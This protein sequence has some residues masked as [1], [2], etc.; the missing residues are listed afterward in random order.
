MYNMSVYRKINMHL[1]ADILRNDAVIIT[2][3][4]NYVKMT[5]FWRHNDVIITSSVRWAV[6]DL[7]SPA[8][9][10]VSAETMLPCAYHAGPT[11]QAL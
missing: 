4:C 3:K 8:S 6:A 7:A 11:T 9:N 10:R 2:S 1:P 5:S